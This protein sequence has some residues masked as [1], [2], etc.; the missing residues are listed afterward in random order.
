MPCLQAAR[1]RLEVPNQVL[2]SPGQVRESL[3]QID[4]SASS[5]GTQPPLYAAQPTEPPG[6]HARQD[7]DTLYQ[8]LRECVREFRHTRY[9]SSR[10]LLRVEGQTAK[11]TKYAYIYIYIYRYTIYI[12]ICN[13]FCIYRLFERVLRN[14]N[15]L[16]ARSS[17]VPHKT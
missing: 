12:Y 5:T 9:V 3:P 17:C 14:G 4:G 11:W 16:D 2:Q 8:H 1:C 13:N 6:G 7:P 15:H 10:N